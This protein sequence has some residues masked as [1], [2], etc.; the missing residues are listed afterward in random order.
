MYLLGAESVYII[1]NEGIWYKSTRSREC[2]VDHL[3]KGHIGANHFVL[4]RDVGGLKC[5]NNMGNEP[6]G[7]LGP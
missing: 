6:L 2:I 7:P 1:I 5:I 4:C 3:N